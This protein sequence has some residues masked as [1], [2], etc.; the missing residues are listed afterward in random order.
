MSTFPPLAFIWDDLILKPV[1]CVQQQLV[2]RTNPDQEKSTLGGQKTS[3]HFNAIYSGTPSLAACRYKHFTAFLE[4]DFQNGFY[5]LFKD[6]IV[7]VVVENGNWRIGLTIGM[8]PVAVGT[9]RRSKKVVGIELKP[10]EDWS[11]EEEDG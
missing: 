11:L 7:S 4:P 8:W 9:R 3:I 1:P 5:L 10:K 2:E 6:L